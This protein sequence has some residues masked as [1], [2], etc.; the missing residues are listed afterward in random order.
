MAPMREGKD[1][2][3]CG[4]QR[5]EIEA[6]AVAALEGVA[7]LGGR[8]ST[9][10]ERGHRRTKG[11]DDSGCST[12]RNGGVDARSEEGGRGGAGTRREGQRC[13]RVE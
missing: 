4:T 3:G 11:R 12:R 1:D 6:A 7:A 13:Q 5:K 2:R 9:W 10:R 8:G